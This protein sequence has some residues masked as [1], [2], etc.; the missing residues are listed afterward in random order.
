MPAFTVLSTTGRAVTVRPSPSD[1]LQSVVVS[2]CSLIPNSGNPENYT[3]QHN[4]KTLSLPT[5]VRL[6]NLPQGAKL[7]LC[8]VN[9][10]AAG[11]SSQKPDAPVKVALQIV[12]AGRIINDFATGSTLWD[13]LVKAESSSGG[14]LNLTTRC[15]ETEKKTDGKVAYQQPVLLLLNKEFST[16]DALQSTTLRSLGFTGGGNV[17]VR[18][19]FK[20]TQISAS[21][22]QK[23]ADASLCASEQKPTAPAELSKT[24]PIQ[25]QALEPKKMKVMDQPETTNMPSHNERAVADNSDSNKRQAASPTLETQQIRVFDTPAATPSSA[26]QLASLDTSEVDPEDAKLLLSIQR[27]R[28]AES[29]RGFKSRLAQEAEERKRREQFYQTHPKTTIR[30]RFPDQVQVQATFLSTDCV[31]KLF[32]FIADVLV[33]AGV[34]SMLVLQPAQDLAAWKAKSLREAGLA[35]AAVVHV[36]LNGDPKVRPSTLELLKPEVGALAQPLEI[37]DSGNVAETSS[38]PS[39]AR[40]SPA[41]TSSALMPELRSS[42]SPALDDNGRAS[43]GPPVASSS[44]TKNRNALRMPKWFYAG[45]RKH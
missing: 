12:G 20:D 17:M 9:S 10:K 1:T 2:A 6:A 36:R 30:F 29:E 16:N 44:A 43:S 5:P 3:L 11:N 8:L 23:M 15:C 31:S 14:T 4:R 45:Q 27:T 35:P 26:S 28:Q 32:V 19:S 13:I 7:Q 22:L 18:L 41:S 25:S 42:A 24:E 21:E 34:L 38:S 39:V 40:D 37:P 33:D